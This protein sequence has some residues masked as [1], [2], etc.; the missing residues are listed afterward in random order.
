LAHALAA[1][2]IRA[3]TGTH[4][5]TASGFGAKT[6]TTASGAAEGWEVF[7]KALYLPLPELV[8]FGG[9]HGSDVGIELFQLADNLRAYGGTEITERFVVLPEDGVQLSALLRVRFSSRPSWV[10]ICSAKISGSG[11]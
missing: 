3:K 4:S 8:L 6:L 10:S 7:L 5:L 2:G 1:T 11:P 9:Q